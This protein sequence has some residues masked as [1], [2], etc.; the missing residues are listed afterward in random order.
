[1]H[2]LS[3]APLLWCLLALQ[4]TRPAAEP[5]PPSRLSEADALAAAV[6]EASGA[7][8]WPKVS[9]LRFTFNVESEGKLA[10]SADHDWDVRANKATVT[11]KGKSVTIDLADPGDSDDAKTAFQRWTNDTYWILMPLKLFD[12][13]VVRTLQPDQQHDGRT[14]RVLR[15]SFQGVGLTPGD[16][17]DLLIDPETHLVRHWDYMPNPERKARFSWDNYQPYGGL[18]LAVEHKSADGKRRIY[19]TNVQVEL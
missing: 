3:L 5:A 10:M 16:Q 8:V 19:F 12:A 2:A 6:A 13:G 17:Y 14:Y 18:K 15:L 9:R 4:T 7:A 11:W 1:M